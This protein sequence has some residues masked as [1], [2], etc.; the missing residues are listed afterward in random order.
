MKDFVKVGCL[1]YA[2]LV[3]TAGDLLVLVVCLE[4]KRDPS[5]RFVA[6]VTHF[7]GGHRR[8]T[9]GLLTRVR[10]DHPKRLKK[11]SNSHRCS[12]RCAKPNV[13]I[14]HVDSANRLRK[15]RRNMTAHKRLRCL[16]LDNT[17]TKK[18]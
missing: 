14:E 10:L 12:D 7:G 1:N 2:K 9:G 18:F 4:L 3:S 13:P 15:Y 17:A 8:Q 5:L 16:Q 6:S 11:A